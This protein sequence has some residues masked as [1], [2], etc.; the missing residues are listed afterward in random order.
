MNF[1]EPFLGKTCDH[2]GYGIYIEPPDGKESYVECNECGAVLLTYEPQPYQ[3]AFHKDP[4]KY[5]GFF[6]GYG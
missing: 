6:G 1:Q 4:A 5:K 2:C 3:E